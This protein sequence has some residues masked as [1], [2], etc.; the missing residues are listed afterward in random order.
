MDTMQPI[1]VTLCLPCGHHADHTTFQLGPSALRLRAYCFA[2]QAVTDVH[3]T[4]A[5]SAARTMCAC[6]PAEPQPQDRA[7]HASP[8]KP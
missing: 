5:I 3:V 1:S 8:R 4:A 7:A 2:C 6:P